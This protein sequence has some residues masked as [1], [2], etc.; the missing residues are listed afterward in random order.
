M[1]CLPLSWWFLKVPYIFVCWFRHSP[2]CLG[3]LSIWIALKH[4][5]HHKSKPVCWSP[6]PYC[7]G[8]IHITL[9]GSEFLQ[10]PRPKALSLHMRV[11]ICTHSVSCP[12][13]LLLALPPNTSRI[14]WLLNTSPATTLLWATH[15]FH[16]NF[17]NVCLISPVLSVPLTKVARIIFE[18]QIMALPFSK[19]TM[20]SHPNLG[21]KPWSSWRPPAL[22]PSSSYL[23]CDLTSHC[24]HLPTKKAST[25]FKNIQPSLAWGLSALGL[26]T[27]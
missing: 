20:G 24:S 6:I 22:Y 18:S 21:A 13:G 19:L 10:C 23:P 1:G 16:L 25:W 9:D 4:L 17:W 3:D 11:V 8:S 26:F 2:N 27:Y 5:W 7:S 15:T 14:W 12:S